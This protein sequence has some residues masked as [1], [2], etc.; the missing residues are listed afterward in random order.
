MQKLVRND[1]VKIINAS[2]IWKNKKAIV[3]SQSND[4][5]FDE[6]GLE[7]TT[8][9]V[10][11]FFGDEKDSK[12]VIQEFPRH[13]LEL[14]SKNESL[15]ELYQNKELNL[16]SVED[17]KEYFIDKSCRFSG[18]DYSKLFKKV[19]KDNGE[20]AYSDEDLEYIAY[21]KSLESLPCKISSC[22][23]IDSFDMFETPEENFNSAY[24]NIEFTNGDTL[25]A[26][27][28]E[29]LI[30]LDIKFESLC[31][32]KE[33]VEDYVKDYVYTA[34]LD[35][36]IPSWFFAD[37]I[38]AAENIKTEKVLKDAKTLG[39]NI[40]EITAD[41]FSKKVIAAKKCLKDV[42]L[43]DYGDYLQG[44]VEVKDI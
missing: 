31:E 18:F 35:D 11:V 29:D 36:D 38:A 20:L 33:A 8:V 27:I 43:D 26:V 1:K 12:T 13:C 44:N 22:A 14:E 9:K 28:G 41:H 39:Y 40:Y 3:I 19:R 16:A 24:W 42:V 25:P 30:L 23:L 34:T 32:A 17:F 7:L 37:K 2:N 15:N 6:N 10:K 4:E 21:Y 5:I